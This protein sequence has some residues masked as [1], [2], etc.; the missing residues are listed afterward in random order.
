IDE[1]DILLGEA[2]EFEE[3]LDAAAAED[4]GD[5]DGL[6]SFAGTDFVDELYNDASD[7]DEEEGRPVNVS[8][9]GFKIKHSSG[10]FRMKPIASTPAESFLSQTNE[11]SFDATQALEMFQRRYTMDYRKKASGSKAADAEDKYFP[12]FHLDM[13]GIVGRPLHPITS[14]SGF[15]DNVTFTLR[16][17][18]SS[19]IGKHVTTNLPFDIRNRTFR[20]ATAAS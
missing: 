15:F 17:W 5:D 18:H 20:I 16:H 4:S 6:E 3:Y 9:D 2:D 7:L 10:S 8:K 13:I 1:P 14:R 11:P 19:Y 12:I